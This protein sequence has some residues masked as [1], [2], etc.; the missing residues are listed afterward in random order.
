VLP[1]FAELPALLARLARAL[2]TVDAA[3]A[4]AVL[5]DVSTEIRLETGQT[6]CDDT[7]ALL[8]DVPPMLAVIALRAAERAMRNP[9]TLHSEGLGDYRRT[10]ADQ[11]QPAGVYLTEGERDLLARIPGVTGV[12]GIVSVPIE[13][14]VMLSDTWYVSDQYGGDRIPWGGGT[15]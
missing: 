7:G 15:L 4:G 9:S 2:S 13:R 10:F 5:D 6:W 1:P 8:P 14:D 12:A 3:R 11:Q